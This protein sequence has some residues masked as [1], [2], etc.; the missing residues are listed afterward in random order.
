MTTTN[1]EAFE[2]ARLLDIELTQALPAISGCAEY[3]TGRYERVSALVRLHTQ[4][5]GV[6]E[7][8]PG[9]EALC[10]AEVAERI[11][12]ALGEDIGKHLLADGLPGA[13][14]L[15]AEGLPAAA[16]ARPQC[17]EERARVLA[18]APFAS[19]V[20][21]TH[22]R[23]EMI[24]ACLA[25]LAALEYPR[26]EIIVVDNAPSTPATAQIV[27]RAAAET[28][29]V[30]YVREDRPGASWARNRGL[31]EARGEIVAFTDD[32][33]EVDR[34]WLAELAKAFA[35][36]DNVGCV[37]GNVLPLKL[38]TSAQAWF[39]ERGGFSRGFTR[40]TYDLREHRS[41]HPLYPYSAMI[42]GS[43]NN[44]AFRT[45]VLREI[46]G[47]DPALDPAS[48][49]RG[50]EDLAAFFEVIVRG[51]ELVYEPAALVRHLHRSDFAGLERQMYAWGTGFIGYLLRSLIAHPAM[52]P[53]FVLK[54]PYALS[55]ALKG[56]IPYGREHVRTLA[57]SYPT[58]RTQA[59]WQAERSGYVHGALR[60]LQSL[61]HVRRVTRRFGPLP[62]GR[63]A[64]ASPPGG[65]AVAR[66]L[67][68]PGAR[69]E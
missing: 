28:P 13:W 6:V 22:D 66:E 20:V 4:P 2:P 52:I 39:E 48:P 53:G 10:P 30:R 27:Q 40:H 41:N 26:Y 35:S 65:P 59:L 5:L 64:P 31:L 47:F 61:R 29:R 9:A 56:K 43:G 17:L 60:Y 57:E 3:G 36:A 14:R 34:H 25:A 16:V 63:A 11:W 8:G 1:D 51:Y 45:S 19:V 18:A 33:V 62:V 46:G 58:A 42:F 7:F 67:A 68:A 23:P 32:D 55:V 15:T 54:V 21:P 38:D 37:T 49:S 12:A 44:M 50:G 24:R 69:H